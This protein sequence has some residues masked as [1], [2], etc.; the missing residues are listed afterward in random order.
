MKKKIVLEVWVTKILWKTKL[1]EGSIWFGAF[2]RKHQKYKKIFNFLNFGK[3]KKYKS[4]QKMKYEV[5]KWNIEV[6]KIEHF[7][8]LKIDTRK[9]VKW[10]KRVDM[11]IV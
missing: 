6:S 7:G 11:H 10:V 9:Q 3:K 1:P 4:F 2:L 5:K 8:N